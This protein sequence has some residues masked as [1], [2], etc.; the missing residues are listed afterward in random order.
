M[1]RGP[2]M[3]GADSDQTSREGDLLLDTGRM[4]A[5]VAVAPLPHA[6]THQIPAASTDLNRRPRPRAAAVAPVAGKH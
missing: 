2:L 4:T 6:G 3:Y 5:I 1:T